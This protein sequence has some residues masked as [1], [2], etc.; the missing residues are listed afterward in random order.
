M[1]LLLVNAINSEAPGK[2][3]PPLGLAYIA[4][5]LRKEFGDKIECRIIDGNLVDEIKDFHPDIVG[6]TS[7]T[8]NY[9]MAKEYAHIAKA[10]N[11]PVIIGG[12][13]ISF[14]PQTLTHDMDIGIVGE[15]E[16]TIIDLMASF[17]ANSG[18]EK[19]ELLDIDGIMFRDLDNMV[20]TRTRELIKPLDNISYPARNL[21]EIKKQTSMLSSRGCPYNCAFCS[22]ARL[23]GNQVRYASAEYVADEIELIHRRYN[24]EYITIYDDLFAIDAKRVI[25]IQERMAAKNLIGKFDIAVNTRTDFITD[26]LAGILRQMNVKVVGLG[27]ESGCQETLDYLKSGGIAVEDNANAI[28]I[29]KKHK[30]IPY[31]SFI[32]GSPFEDKESLMQTVRF[33]NDNKVEY[34]DC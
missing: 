19:S 3:H 16:K 33:I 5:S 34:F 24:V 1:K 20:I 13:H 10:F 14:I 25:E 32:I 31:C 22:T 26:E 9:N 8:R 4:A 29:L 7:V 27:V 6:I 17:M 28:R 18:F 12:V 30:I 15:G 2:L 23:T 21:L 11:V